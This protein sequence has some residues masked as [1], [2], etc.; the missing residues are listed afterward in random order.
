[1]ARSPKARA[2]EPALDLV[3]VVLFPVDEL[4]PNPRNARKHGD[5][6]VAEIETSV[7]ENGWTVP[8]LADLLDEATII[9]GH[10]RRLA[11]RKI[12][13]AGDI[14]RT[15]NGAALPAGMVPVI[16]CSGW[17]EEQRRAYTIA[18]NKIA[19][20]A[21]W[22]D[23][24]LRLELGELRDAGVEVV[25]L[26]FDAGE[27]KSI[28]DG[29]T[30]DIDLVER[31]GEHTEGISRTVKVTVKQDDVGKAKEAIGAALRDAGIE[32]EIA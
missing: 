1:M 32:A 13:A 24:L 4:T 6:Q 23:D 15:P 14:I 20:N 17:T 18:D 27:L 12:Y 11:A 28:L 8:I 31:D 7:R 25:N 3:R 30:T 29:W 21:T 22:D 2:D 10:G 16:D 5:Q 19:E 26:G 9:A